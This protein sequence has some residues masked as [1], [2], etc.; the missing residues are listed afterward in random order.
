MILEFNSNRLISPSAGLLTICHLSITFSL[1]VFRVFLRKWIMSR[2]FLNKISI[3]SDYQLGP[4]TVRRNNK[5]LN[6]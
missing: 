3:N 4:I 2:T 6:L 1:I 5:Y